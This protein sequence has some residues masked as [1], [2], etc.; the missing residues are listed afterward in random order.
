MSQVIYCDSFTDST[1]DQR[2]YTYPS[3]IQVE[4]PTF[5]HGTVQNVEFLPLMGGTGRGFWSN[6]HPPTAGPHFDM[7]YPPQPSYTSTTGHDSLPHTITQLAEHCR[8]QT[9]HDNYHVPI[10]PGAQALQLEYYAPVTPEVPSD[11]PLGY[12]PIPDNVAGS[13]QGNPNS[14][15]SGMLDNED[16]K[17]LASCYLNNHSAH[18][19]KLLVRRRFP[20]GRRVL[21][22]LEIDDVM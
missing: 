22:V 18:V 7:N 3:T 5:S 9:N 11:D 6:E 17:H 20:G 13:S 10:A 16:L 4:T 14:I 12:V 1:G 15:H 21:I 8:D 2:L 19:D